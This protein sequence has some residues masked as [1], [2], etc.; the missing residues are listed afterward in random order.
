MQPSDIFRIGRTLAAAV[1]LTCIGLAGAP[2]T[3]ADDPTPPP[4]YVLTDARGVV[5]GVI[6]EEEA[7]RKALPKGVRPVADMAGGIVIYETGKG[8]GLGGYTAAYFYVNVEGY[9][10]P[11]GTKANWMLQGVYGPDK[12]V[13]QALKQHYKIPVRAGV[14]TIQIAPEGHRYV[15]LI[16]DQ[17]IVTAEIKTGACEAAHAFEHYPGFNEHTGEVVLLAIPEIGE[18]CAAE[19]KS[20]DVRPPAGDPFSMFKV[21]S[22]AWAGEFRDWS[23]SFTEPRILGK[24]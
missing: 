5:I 10:S 18:W 15:A 20:L 2:A 6:W 8:Y 14:A 23:F 22:V 7:I 9:D 21:K 24:P 4:P 3:A 13:S 1:C 11:E 12:R 17:A 16:D 19:V